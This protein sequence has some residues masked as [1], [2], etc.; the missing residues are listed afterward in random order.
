V[1]AELRV[2]RTFGRVAAEYERA[3]PPYAREA[4]ELASADLAL[5]RESTVLDLAAGTGKLT[6][7]LAGLFAYVI[8][9][10][11]DDSM[12]ANI[13]GDVRAGSAEQ[14]PLTDGSVDAV[15]V[16]DAVHWFDAD[17]ALAEI[18]RVALPRGGLVVLSNDWWERESP[19][20]PPAARARLD[21][22]YARFRPARNSNEDWRT[23]FERVLGPLREAELTTE[24]SYDRTAM[25]DLL[26]SMSGPAALDAAERAELR[27]TLHETLE[28]GY[29]INVRT[30]IFW[31]RLP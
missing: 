25:T 6:R 9:V 4:V 29:M 10:E 17:P 12:R 16:G 20:V 28:S 1:S 14:I 19:R 15:F 13:D 11:P 5:K 31:G 7:T 23:D 22:V 27:T 18:A 3:R 30:S 21:E 8:A 2:G 24:L 26:L